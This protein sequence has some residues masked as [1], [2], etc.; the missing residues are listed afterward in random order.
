[1]VDISVILYGNSGQGVNTARRVLGKAAFLT[2][3]NVRDW[4]VRE[5]YQRVGSAAGY[6]LLSREAI[7]SNEPF[8][9]ADYLLVFGRLTQDI[10][11]MCK[12]EGIVIANSPERIKNAYMAQ[13]NIKCNAVDADNI[14]A[15]IIGK[16]YPGMAMLGA[17]ARI[18]G[19]IPMKNIKAVISE[20]G[21]KKS[22]NQ[23]AFEEGYKTV[24]LR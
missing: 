10:L 24:K 7:T 5:R 11:K 18:S 2:G 22:E 4:Y 8:D 14:A 21:Y 20:M 17:F 3:F 16:D 19:K 23:N 13:H 12:T 6:M 15:K 1:M 9:K